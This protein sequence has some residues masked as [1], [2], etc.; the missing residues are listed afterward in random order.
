MQTY[1]IMN[2]EKMKPDV[3]KAVVIKPEGIPT[4]NAQSLFRPKSTKCYIESQ[5]RAQKMYQEAQ[6]KPR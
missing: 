4:D 5:G 6:D 2:S 3:Q 1:F